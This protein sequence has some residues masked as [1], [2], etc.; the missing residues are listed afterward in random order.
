MPVV[1]AIMAVVALVEF[2]G[3]VLTAEKLRNAKAPRNAEDLADKS[4]ILRQNEQITALQ[5][6]VELWKQQIRSTN[7]ARLTEDVAQRQVDQSKYGLA[8]AAA[9]EQMSRGLH[10]IA[11]VEQAPAVYALTVL[12]SHS[13][14]GFLTC[15]VKGDAGSQGLMLLNILRLAEKYSVATV[16][17]AFKVLQIIRESNPDLRQREQEFLSL[18]PQKTRCPDTVSYYGTMLNLLH[19]GGLKIGKLYFLALDG[20]VCMGED[21]D[22]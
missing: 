17:P 18:A 15:G 10:R 1:L 12:L 16:G 5:Q 21:E 11:S 19:G 20:I 13:M 8:L 2:V 7:G 14:T 22:S 9:V 3:W 4:T 6:E